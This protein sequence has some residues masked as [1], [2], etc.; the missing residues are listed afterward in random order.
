MRTRTYDGKEQVYCPWRRKYV[1]LTP[2]ER[3][4][5]TFLQLLVEQYD[6]PKGLISVEAFLPDGKRADAV[7]YSRTLTP[8]MIIEFKADTVAL[9]QK[10]ID[11]AVVYNR[12]L[13]VPYLVLNNGLGTIVVRVEEHE[14]IYLQDIPRWT[15]L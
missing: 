5:Q 8:L 1:R 9:N 2:E 10:V 15:Q 3:V 11:Q 14:H 12:Q 7:V 6:Y 4:R 13:H